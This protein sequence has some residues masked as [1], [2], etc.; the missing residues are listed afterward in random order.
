M[1]ARATR[2][3]AAAK[4]T[5]TPAAVKP[6]LTTA[7]ALLKEKSSKK[8]LEGMARYGLPSDKAWGVPVSGIQAVAKKLGRDHDLAAALWKTDVYEAR[9]LC[10]FVD[11]PEKVTPAQMDRWCRDF[12]NWGIVDTICFCLF[13][14]TP[15]A[16]KKVPEWSARKEEFQKRAGFVLLACLAAHDKASGDAPF[17]RCMPLLE[18]GATDE[19][20]FVKKGVSWALR[21]VGRRSPALY[22]SSVA[23]SKRLLES[24][25]EAARWIGKEA[26]RDLSKP[27]LVKKLG[28]KRRS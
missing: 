9:M 25:S 6:T 17:A 15:H 22:A 7:L 4:A 16:W 19:R 27:A 11:E 5:R 12:D 23:L 8:T 20:N 21:G 2:A 1:K 28:G 13:D 14:R 10:A 3:P 24:K 26:L 18:R